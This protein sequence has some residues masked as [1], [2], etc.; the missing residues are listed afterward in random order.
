MT[1]CRGKNNVRL[2]ET[3]EVGYWRDL[4]QEL[5]L[6]YFASCFWFV[7]TPSAKIIYC[8][9]RPT[10]YTR[11]RVGWVIYWMI[12]LVCQEVF[13]FLCFFFLLHFFSGVW[14]G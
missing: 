2:G 11:F 1:F 10:K 3:L 8:E 14:V 7:F 13:C 5:V 6:F 12:V 4:I 9:S